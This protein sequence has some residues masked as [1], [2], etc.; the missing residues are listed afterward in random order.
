MINNIRFTGVMIVFLDGIH[1]V[2]GRGAMFVDASH[3]PV[4]DGAAIVPTYGGPG[5]YRLERR[6]FL[7]S[8][9]RYFLG[10]H[11][12][13]LIQDAST[14]SRSAGA[15]GDRMQHPLRSPVDHGESAAVTSFTAISKHVFIVAPASR[16][17]Y[18]A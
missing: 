5:R 7:G 14:C 17:A 13:F 12:G 3:G 10:R 4:T 15:D 18:F 1:R 2:G 16:L 11:D 9:L 8:F 6:R